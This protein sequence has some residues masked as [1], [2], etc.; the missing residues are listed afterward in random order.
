[1]LSDLYLVAIFY[2]AASVTGVGTVLVIWKNN[3][4]VL[5]A[6]IALGFASIP[7]LVPYFFSQYRLGPVKSL[8]NLD[9]IFIYGLICGFIPM[10]Q[11]L[12]T[13]RR[14]L[15]GEVFSTI[16]ACLLVSLIYMMIPTLPETSMG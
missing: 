5:R 6:I 14:L 10:G 12:R 2:A 7:L 3:G 13:K 4:A 9:E 15:P 11:L 1:M 16:V 8:A